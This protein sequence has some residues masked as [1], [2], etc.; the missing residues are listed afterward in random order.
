MTKVAVVILNYNGSDFLKTFLPTLIKHTPDAD[1]IVADNCSTDDSLKVLDAFTEIKTIQLE[2]NFGYAGGYNKALEQISAKYYI[3]LNS[4]VEVTANWLAPLVEYLDQ[5]PKYAA[6]QPKLLDYQERH[7]FEYAGASGG[8]LDS[9]GYPYCRGRIF[10]HLETDEH[11]YNEVL[12]IFWSSGA[13]FLVRSEAFHQIGGFDSSFF[14]HMEEIDLCWRLKSIG[15]HI[16]CIPE[17]QVYHVG[18]GTL[19]KINPRKTYLNFRNGMRLLVKNLPIE[20]LLFKIPLRAFL[21]FL[22]SFQ[23]L[24]TQSRQHFFAVYQA[25]WDVLKFIVRDLKNSPRS[26]INI[27]NN[28]VKSIVFQYFIRKVKTFDQLNNTK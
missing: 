28:N 7:R 18:G 22:A 16:A 21:D 10:D 2:E 13:T 5:N 27:E 26:K 11:Q 9:L 3:L 17:S 12:D 14:A 1:L 20:Q 19:N 24:I 23:L 25:Y 15:Y 6:V 8:F 4:D